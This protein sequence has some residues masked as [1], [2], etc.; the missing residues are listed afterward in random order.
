MK[1]IG[2]FVCHC[3]TNI[4]GVVDIKGVTTAVKTLKNV[5]VVRDYI[6]ICSSQGNEIIRK[7]IEEYRL[8]GVVIAS[9]SPKVHEGTFRKTIEE[10]GLN[11]YL[12]EVAN[13]REQVS[14][15]TEDKADATKKAIE[16]IQMKIKKVLKLLPL[17]ET[18][19]EITKKVLVIGGGIAGVEAALKIANN[20]HEVLLVEKSPSIGGRMA[21]LD[22]TF[23]TLDCSACIL[24]PKLVEAG[25]HPLIKI[26]TNSEVFEVSGFV[27]NF[28]AKILQ[29]VRYV[30]IDKCKGCGLC[31]I[32][33]PVKVSSGI[34]IGSEERP[35]IYSPFPQAYPKA[36]TIDRENCLYLTKGKCGLCSKVCS[37]GAINYNEK[38]NVLE[39]SVGA[40]I[41][42][43]GNDLF[44]ANKY[45]EYGYGRYLNVITGFQFE[46]FL[47]PSGPTEGKLIKPSDGK[48]PESIAFVHCVGS[49]DSA[50]GVSH[51]SK[52]CCMVTA[53]QILIAKIKNPKARIYSFYI[54]LRAGGKNYEEFVCQAREKEGVNFIK[55]RVSNILKVNDKLLV[56]AENIFEG[57]PVRIEVDM[58]VLA[59]GMLPNPDAIKLA[60]V[61][62]IEYDKYGFYKELHP[63]LKP[64]STS[65][66][67]IF[68]AGTCSGAMDIPDTVSHAAASAANAL[69][70]LSDE[71]I[72]KDPLVSSVRESACTGC[73]ACKDVCFYGAI[74]E[75]LI[76]GRLI[77]QVNE[78]V[79]H[80]CGN[81]TSQ[82]P[83][84]SISLNGSTDEQIHDEIIGALY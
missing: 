50:K 39:E 54:D 44:D 71:Y 15:C 36:P 53:K 16:L 28:T 3:G 82:C 65:R 47:S 11:P 17:E 58:V 61:L 72:V 60:K 10:A 69:E 81:C 40:I 66:A 9:C 74:N 43:T 25:S 32:K 24:S 42:A 30:D 73:F 67:G 2:V 49:R 33:C 64:V 22:K 5:A 68:I 41:V 57:K 4:S 77:A 27:G 55:G 56:K 20:G 76:N 31:S 13:I 59:C 21:Y 52:V 6:Y 19:L 80:G 1:R 23:P 46:K 37:S 75:V 45:T 83:N 14:W 26:Y 62:G 35:A 48:E 12:F 8:N 63:K 38:D 34:N 78:A 29:K 70:I 84:G 79:C 51:C 18:R 7:M